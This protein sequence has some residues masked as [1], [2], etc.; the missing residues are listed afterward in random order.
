MNAG[1]IEVHIC[2][3]HRRTPYPLLSYSFSRVFELTSVS[4]RRLFSLLCVNLRWVLDEFSVPAF[5]LFALYWG[6]GNLYPLVVFVLIHMFISAIVHTLFSG[7]FSFNKSYFLACS[8]R[9]SST[10]SSQASVP[11]IKVIFWHVHLGHCPH[12]LLRRVSL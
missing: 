2:I 9:P 8:S 6:P 4:V 7:E 1:S 3:V 12:T 5:Q 11:L 10:H